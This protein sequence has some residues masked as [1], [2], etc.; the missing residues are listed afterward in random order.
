MATSLLGAQVPCPPPCELSIFLTMTM[1]LTMSMTIFVIWAPLFTENCIYSMWSEWS[2]CPIT[3][4][5]YNQV[6]PG[7]QVARLQPGSSPRNWGTTEG[8]K[9][10]GLIRRGKPKTSGSTTPVSPRRC[11]FKR[12]TGRSWRESGLAAPVISWWWPRTRLGKRTCWYIVDKQ[13]HMSLYFL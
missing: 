9:P 6:S 11:R 4:I 1:T 5:E 8:S 3:C 13:V 2:P 12:G 7:C 10:M